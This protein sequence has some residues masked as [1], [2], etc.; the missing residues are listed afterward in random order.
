MASGDAGIYDSVGLLWLVLGVSPESLDGVGLGG[1]EGSPMNQET[2]AL[3]VVGLVILVWVLKGIQNWI[4]PAAS[5]WLLAHKQV[6]LAF[7]L[8]RWSEIG[9]KKQGSKS[10]DCCD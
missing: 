5:K 8:R 1:E 2:I 3:S 7:Q 9:K 6:G 4:L 10:P